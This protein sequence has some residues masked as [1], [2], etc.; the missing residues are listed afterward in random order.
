[1]CLTSHLAAKYCGST[2]R[3]EPFRMIGPQK[4]L[5]GRHP[6]ICANLN[7]LVVEMHFFTSYDNEVSRK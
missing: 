7:L 6:F 1:M 4:T 5:T 2:I 3:E